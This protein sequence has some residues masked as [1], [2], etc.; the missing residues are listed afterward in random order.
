MRF[1]DVGGVEENTISQVEGVREQY[2]AKFT[3]HRDGLIAMAAP[4]G[5]RFMHARTDE[6]PET[7]LARAY[8]LLA[9]KRKA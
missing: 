7:V 3:A 6:K 2:L 9:A 4:L 5:W 8:D 1:Q